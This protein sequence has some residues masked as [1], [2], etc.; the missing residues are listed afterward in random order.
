METLQVRVERLPEAWFATFHALGKSPE[1][2]A[3]RSLREW[4]ALRGMFRDPERHPVFGFNNPPPSRE[5]GEYGYELWIGVGEPDP[6]ETNVEFKRFA[7]G[8]YAVT[9]CK[10]TGEP[11]VMACWRSLWDWVQRSPYRWRKSQELERVR[12]PNAP[13]EEMILDLYL[14]I[15]ER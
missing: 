2:V 1:N 3:W 13:E 8:L 14:P 10:L 6:A 7:G 9:T 5:S 11:G 4:A 12:D 15:A